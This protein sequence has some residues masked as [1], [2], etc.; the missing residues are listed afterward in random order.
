MIVTMTTFATF[1]N[2]N[3]FP[4]FLGLRAYCVLIGLL[5]VAVHVHDVSRPHVKLVSILMIFDYPQNEHSSVTD[6]DNLIANVH[7]STREH[8]GMC[9]AHCVCMLCMCT[10]V[11]VVQYLPWSGSE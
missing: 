8:A 1:P 6:G 11:S 4:N 10:A 7:V 9:Q 2:N 3:I 5:A